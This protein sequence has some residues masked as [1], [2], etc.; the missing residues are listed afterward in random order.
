[1]RGVGLPAPLLP[2]TF[3]LRVAPCGPAAG[4]DRPRGRSAPGQGPKPSAAWPQSGGRSLLRRRRPPPPSPFTWRLPAA[5]RINRDSGRAGAAAPAT[6]AP[7][8][9]ADPS[10]SLARRCGSL[11]SAPLRPVPLVAALPPAL[12][13][14]LLPAAEATQS[15]QNGGGRA[16][17]WRLPSNRPHPSPL[18]GGRGRAAALSPLQRGGGRCSRG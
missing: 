8:T 16:A 18:A 15:S 2:Q 1:M 9:E 13:L 17:R 5:L 6:S 4:S 11:L 7:F 10:A 14:C 12:C 3:P